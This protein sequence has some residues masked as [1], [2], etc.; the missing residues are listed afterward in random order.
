MRDYFGDGRKWGMEIDYS[1]TA[2]EDNT[3][4]R[5]KL[6]EK[7]LED[8]FLLVYCDNYWPMQM[9]RMWRR[10]VEAGAPAMQAGQSVLPHRKSAMKC[11]KLND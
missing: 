5:I 4:R 6:A 3:G 10:F 2:V 11:E 9:D 1:I 7:K 8:I